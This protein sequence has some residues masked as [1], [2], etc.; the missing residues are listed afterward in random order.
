MVLISPANLLRL[1]L[2][3][4]TTRLRTRERISY[5]LIVAHAAIPPS[6]MPT[7]VATN[8]R[9]HTPGIDNEVLKDKPSLNW[10]GPFKIPPDRRQ[11][12]DEL[13]EHNLPSNLSG[14]V[15][16]PPALLQH[17]ASAA[18]TCLHT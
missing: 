1:P 15:A 13:L 8:R 17:V 3:M 10:I 4:P 14:P 7:S 9:H 11:V 12:G 5:P 2:Q 16:K 18:P 6:L